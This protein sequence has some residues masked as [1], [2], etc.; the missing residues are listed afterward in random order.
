MTISTKQRFAKAN[1]SGL[2]PSKI[3]DYASHAMRVAIYARAST[4]DKSQDPENQLRELRDWANNSG[5]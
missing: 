5:R 3:V 1:L 4:D 2:R